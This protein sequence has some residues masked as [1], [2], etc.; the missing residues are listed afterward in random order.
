MSVY[1]LD[2][3]P[4]FGF[5]KEKLKKGLYKITFDGFLTLEENCQLYRSI[6]KLSEVGN[7]KIT[8]LIV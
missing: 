3:S 8:R 7:V 2:S 5:V 4:S 1:K 6:W